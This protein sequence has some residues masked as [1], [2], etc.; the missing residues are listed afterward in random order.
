[1]IE[2]HP[3]EPFV[4]KNSKY[5]LLGSFVGRS[6][7]LQNMWYYGTK[8]TQFWRIL[9]GVYGLKLSTQ[10]DKERLFS[11][12]KLA[13]TDTILQCEREKGNN[14]DIN[15]INVVYNVHAVENILKEN[16]V[17]RIYFSSR[18]AENNYRKHFKSVIE[19]YPN[20]ELVT[21]PS[22][23]PRYAAMPFKAKVERYKELLP[24][25]E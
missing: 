15:L 21:L 5:L 2:T 3:L 24:K 6:S 18:F 17:E 8:T 9:E 25:A 14:S 4:P 16:Q 23:S 12:I 1:M 19:K 11:K 20:I 22:P 13:I 10:K 7:S